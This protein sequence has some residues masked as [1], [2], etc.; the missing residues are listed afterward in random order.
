MLQNMTMSVTAAA[1][2]HSPITSSQHEGKLLQDFN[3]TILG[4]CLKKLAGRI[5]TVSSDDI[6]E[7]VYYLKGPKNQNILT[8]FTLFAQLNKQNKTRHIFHSFGKK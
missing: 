7:K 8:L 4:Y 3:T 5:P 6:K 1:G 2:L